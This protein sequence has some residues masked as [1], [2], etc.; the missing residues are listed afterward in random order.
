MAKRG[1]TVDVS[2]TALDVV[3]DDLLKPL[4]TAL[5]ADRHLAGPVVATDSL[6]RVISV[7][8]SVDAVSAEDAFRRAAARI[9]RAMRQCGLGEKVD[10]ADASVMRDLQE[11]GFASSRD[12]VV[13][14]PDVAARLGI[15]RQRVAQL[16]GQ[17]GRFPHPIATI[18]GTS[19]WRWG[20]IADWIA[21]GARDLRRRRP[22]VELTKPRKRRHQAA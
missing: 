20:D 22:A 12:D 10:F 16:V 14:T 1:Y 15:S 8:T 2:T 7:R 21:A 6:T 17:P 18:R 13:G 4:A 9:R 19:V 5:A 3:D 11:D